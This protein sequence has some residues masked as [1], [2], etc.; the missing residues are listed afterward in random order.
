MDGGVYVRLNFN[1]LAGC[2]LGFSRLRGRV[3]C[4]FRGMVGLIGAHHDLLGYLDREPV[5]AF[6]HWQS[7]LFLLG[8][9]TFRWLIGSLAGPNF[10]HLDFSIL[11]IFL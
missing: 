5:G 2:N 8:F 3:L 10:I 9:N 4:W 6:G 7:L 1:F 11:I